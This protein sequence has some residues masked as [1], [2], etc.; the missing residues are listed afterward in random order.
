MTRAPW[1]LPKPEAAFP[2][3]DQTLHSTTLG[4]RLVNPRMPA[5]WTVALG[6]GAEILADR[7][8]IGRQ[9]QDAYA[10]A[11]HHKA[12]AGWDGG[13]YAPE[14]VPVAAAEGTSLL[15]SDEGIRSDSSMEALARLRPAFRD[16][17]TV[18]AGNSSPLSDGAAALLLGDE[19]SAARLGVEPLARIAARGVSAVDPPLFGIAPVTAAEQALKRAGAAL[20]DLAV[21]ELN[22]AFAAQALACL[23]EWPGLDPDRVNPNGGAVAIGHPIGASGARIVTSLAWELRRRGG[24][25]GLA[26]ICIG[27][28]Q[29][30]A[31]VLDASH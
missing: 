30:L 15:A 7:Y 27:V 18:T 14:S 19:A 28:G 26:A 25:L 21:V 8:G 24:G 23:A 31:L 1:V 16:G 6:E 10:L 5:Q 12:R 29:G 20:D 22:E 9:A 3:A 2:S 13:R 4:W 17:G 11:S